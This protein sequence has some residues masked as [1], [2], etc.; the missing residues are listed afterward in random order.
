[1]M[2][3]E[4]ILFGSIIGSILRVWKY[5]FYQCTQSIVPWYGNKIMQN[6]YKTG[7]MLS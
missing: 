6:Y 5:I 2:V 7:D 4:V 1:M 3:K